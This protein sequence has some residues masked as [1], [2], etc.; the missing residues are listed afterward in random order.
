MQFSTNNVKSVT[1]VDLHVKFNLDL[2]NIAGMRIC[3][4]GTFFYHNLA[5]L[6]L[7][8]DKLGLRFLWKLEIFLE[9][10]KTMKTIM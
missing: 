9:S 7:V 2:E 1:F 8:I 5:D 10:F 4:F 3:S 6:M